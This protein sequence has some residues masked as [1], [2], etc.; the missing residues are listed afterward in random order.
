[1]QFVSDLI[2]K[3]TGWIDHLF[4]WGDTYTAGYSKLLV[5]GLLIF[6]LSKMLKIKLNINSGGGK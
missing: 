6:L 5:Y 4:G 3:I 2:S 1:M